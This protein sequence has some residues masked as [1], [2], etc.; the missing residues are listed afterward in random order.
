MVTIGLNL[1]FNLTTSLA[2]VGSSHQFKIRKV[3]EHK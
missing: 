3:M 1:I 2:R